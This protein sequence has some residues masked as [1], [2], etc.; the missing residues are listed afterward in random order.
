MK[1]VLRSHPTRHTSDCDLRLLRELADTHA[2]ESLRQ[3]VACVQSSAELERNG[4]LV[5]DVSLPSHERFEC[6]T[7]I[8]AAFVMGGDILPVLDVIKRTLADENVELKEY[9]ASILAQYHATKKEFG[10]A[11]A[12]LFNPDVY[13]RRGAVDGLQIYTLQKGSHPQIVQLLV[14]AARDQ[15]EQVTT[16]A[17]ETLEFALDCGSS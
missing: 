6:L 3:I 13:L 5:S 1:R 7:R 15:D 9:S 4:R 14:N 8:G 11:A 17:M 12:L 10:D 16:R 2:R